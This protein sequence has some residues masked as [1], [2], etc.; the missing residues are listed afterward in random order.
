MKE[1]AERLKDIMIEKELQQKQLIK[2]TSLDE[3][4]FSKFMKGKRKIQTHEIIQIS[5]QYN[6]DLNWFLTGNG[7]PFLIDSEDFEVDQIIQYLNQEHKNSQYIKND[8]IQ[9]AVINILNKLEY[10]ELGIVNN[11]PIFLLIKILKRIAKINNIIDTKGY[12]KKAIKDNQEDLA[13]TK[14]NLKTKMDDL[15]DE[16]NEI[17]FKHSHLAV[18]ILQGRYSFF[19]KLFFMNSL[20]N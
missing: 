9:L 11:R 1:I 8:L 13:S 2:N 19:T 14:D 20:T 15:T 3:T 18:L 12:F 17:L 4:Q 5:Q 6:I 10:K 16:E 7:Q